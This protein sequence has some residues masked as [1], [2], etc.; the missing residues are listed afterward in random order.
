MKTW[1]ADCSCAASTS[2][3]TGH[4]IRR[5]TAFDAA[6]R[7]RPRDPET[8]HT[9]A[10]GIVQVLTQIQRWRVWDAREPTLESQRS[11]ASS[12]GRRREA[13]GRPEPDFHQEIHTGRG[14][15]QGAARAGAK[16]SS[17]M[18]ERRWCRFTPRGDRLRAVTTRRSNRGLG[19][20]DAH[21]SASTPQESPCAT[22]MGY[23]D[24][25]LGR[26]R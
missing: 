11:R 18:P 10:S 23:A 19:W 17:S 5:W 22:P 12:G 7:P 24:E 6:P 21:R 1:C 15:A 20:T 4:P 14:T 26:R 9:L 8:T 13:A 16:G 3:T 25:H 2:E